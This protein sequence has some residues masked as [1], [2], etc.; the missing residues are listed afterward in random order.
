MSNKIKDLLNSQRKPKERV[1]SIVESI[2]KDVTSFEQLMDIFRTGSDVEKGSCAEVMKFVSK[3]N[4]EIFLA[5]ID[6]LIDNINHKAS[7][8]KWGIP[9]S[10]GNIAQKYP[11]EVQKAI[12]NLLKN[13]TDKSTVVRWCASYA[14]SEIVKYNSEIQNEL[15]PKINSIIKREKNN[16]VKNVYL[17]ALNQ[18]NE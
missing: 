10:I 13:T 1:S 12:P 7:R 15:I 14:L 4:P 8:V 3:D 17:N 2:K 11:K 6:E 5:Y 18:I 16:G 9:E